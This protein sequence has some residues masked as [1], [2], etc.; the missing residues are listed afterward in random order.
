LSLKPFVHDSNNAN[1]QSNKFSE[2][3]R[4]ISNLLVKTESDLRSFEMT[5]IEKLSCGGMHIDLSF[6]TAVSASLKIS[7]ESRS[8]NCFIIAVRLSRN[9]LPGGANAVLNQ[10]KSQI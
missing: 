3:L 6:F 7:P 5:S 9:F 10:P 2:I 8:N 4:K 1:F